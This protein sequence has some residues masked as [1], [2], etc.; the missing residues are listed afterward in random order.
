MRRAIGSLALV[1]RLVRI[2][3]LTLAGAARMTMATV[4]SSRIERPQRV[5]A[6]L[7][8]LLEMLG[9][10]FIKIGQLAGTR[11]DLVGPTVAGALSRL[12]DG[13]RP[14]TA[15]DAATVVRR[16]LPASGEEFAR[17]L[18]HPPVASGSIASVYRV[19]LEGR[20]VALKVRRPEIGPELT[21]DL[22]LMR[23]VAR[24]GTAI[25]GLRRV[26][27]TEIVEQVVLPG[28]PIGLRH[29]GR[30]AAGARPSP[31][32]RPGHRRAGPRAGIVRGRS[33]RNGVRRGP[34]ARLC[35][36]GPRG[37]PAGT[38][39]PARPSRLPAP[40]RRRVR[41]RRPASRQYLLPVGRNRG[42]A[43]CRLHL[44]ARPR[45]P[46]P[47]RPV[48]RR[49]G[50]RRRCGLRRNSPGHRARNLVRVRHRRFPSRCRR[51]GG[52]QRGRGSARFRPSRVLR[53]AVQPAAPARAL[54]RTRI[55]LPHDVAAQPRRPREGTLSAHGLP[56]RGGPVRHGVLVVAARSRRRPDPMAGFGAGPRS[57][58]RREPHNRRPCRNGPER[59]NI[60]TSRPVIAAREDQLRP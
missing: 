11:I 47:V 12:H 59:P 9:G 25:P 6:E 44:P 7:V 10:A 53:R 54:C 56:A 48:L 21:A 35:W 27:M 32:R 49:Y 23:A 36:S 3:V 28:R 58:D 24:L 51:A 26:P 8:W 15:L 38:G 40:V 33:P 31:G 4:V 30:E 60:R 1:S 42:G 16:A 50:P 46:D 34:R 43:G 19:E 5:A 39:H 2:T 18:V 37:G 55:R 20:V 22:A 52:A 29:R 14:M 17:A 13:V 41:P 57:V 45:R